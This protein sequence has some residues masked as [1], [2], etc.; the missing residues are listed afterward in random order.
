MCKLLRSIPHR[1]NFIIAPLASLLLIGISNTV[2]AASPAAA[3]LS[4][5]STEI[6][7]AHNQYRRKH[8]APALTWSP[9]LARGAQAWANACTRNPENKDSFAHSDP[10]R[11]AEAYGE[12][13]YW[14][15]SADAN[16]AVDLWYSEVNQYDFDRPRFSGHVG[17]FTQLVWLG[18]RQLGCGLASC[19]GLNFWVCRYSPPGNWNVNQ[20]GVLVANVKPPCPD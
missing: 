11:S 9:E 20:P 6:L 3:G 12:N 8:C 18:S 17:H 10:T 15:T 13:L 16:T 4:P 2:P 7:S 14:G 19:G 1:S 5:E